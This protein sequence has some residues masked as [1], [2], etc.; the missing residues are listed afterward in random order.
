MSKPI[1][2]TVKV[3]LTIDPDAWATEYGLGA[4]GVAAIREDAKSHLT[5]YVEDLV[6][7][8]GGLSYLYTAEVTS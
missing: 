8:I 1:T 6:G 3:K 5:A 4:G 7:T 2:I